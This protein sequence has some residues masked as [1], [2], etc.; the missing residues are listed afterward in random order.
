MSGGTPGPRRWTRYRTNV[1][2]YLT[3]VVAACVVGLGLILVLQERGDRENEAAVSQGVP[4][5]EQRMYAD[6]LEA[7]TEQVLAFTNVD[8]RTLQESVKAVRAGATGEFRKQYDAS[9]DGLRDVMLANRSVMTGEILSA[10]IVAA[11][12]DSAT[13]L[14]ATKGHV[15][16]TRTQGEKQE[17]NLRLQLE[18]TKVEDRWLTSGLQF[19]G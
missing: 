3:T 17:R 2:L 8:H 9:V 18:L 12:G 19:V 15:E 4:A 11:D 1:A 7:A 14:V 16:N 10:G 13:V 5:D 6:V